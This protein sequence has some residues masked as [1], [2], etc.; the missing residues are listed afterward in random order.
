MYIRVYTEPL[1]GEHESRPRLFFA[2]YEACYWF[3]MDEGVGRL[4]AW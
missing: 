1:D 4:L 2:A 3:V